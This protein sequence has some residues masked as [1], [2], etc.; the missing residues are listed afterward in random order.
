MTAHLVAPA[1][2]IA[3]FRHDE[4]PLAALVAA[5]AVSRTRVQVVIPA[6]DEESTIGDIVTAVRR[7]LVDGAGLVDD[8]L[9][10]DDASADRTADVARAAGAEIVAGP[11]LGKG[12]AMAAG[13][14]ALEADP[15]RDAVIVFLDGDVVGFGSCFVTGLLGP[16]LSDPAVELVKGFYRRPIGDQPLGGGRV[17]EL[18][19]KPALQLVFPALASVEQPLAGET[20]VRRSLYGDLELASG[21]A[22]EV[23]M[24]IDTLSARGTRAMAQVDLGVRRHR[25]RPLAALVPQAREVLAAILERSPGL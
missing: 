16:L 14:A 3:R 6:R 22:V 12:E 9:V 15:G 4:F 5:K 8:L 2:P 21:Y 1:A 17:T 18:V 11:G 10:V 13:A 24:L 20:A 23:A 25:N 19:A 7:E